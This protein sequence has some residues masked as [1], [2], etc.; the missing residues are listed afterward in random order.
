MNETVTGIA[1]M[2]GAATA[3]FIGFTYWT[4]PTCRVGNVPMFV[5]TDGWSCVPGYKPDSQ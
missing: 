3:V 2:L 4:K 5:V 1:V